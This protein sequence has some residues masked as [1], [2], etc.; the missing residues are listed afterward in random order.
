MKDFKTIEAY[1]ASYPKD[2]RPI[3]KRLRATIQKVIP[4]ATES[5]SYGMPSYSQNGAYVVH[6]GGFVKHVSIFPGPGPIQAFRKEL[7]GYKTSRGTIQFPLGKPVPYALVTRIIK[8]SLRTNNER[9]AAKA[10]AKGIH[11]E[12]HTDGSIWAQGKLKNRTMDGLWEWY[13]KEGTIMRSGY[14]KNGK[15]TG[16]WTTYDRKGKVYKVTKIKVKK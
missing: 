14:F 15:Q 2:V 3:L 5:I 1:I 4:G 12:F 6:L 9:I 13:R 16:T 7:A 11:V 10:Q 8:Y